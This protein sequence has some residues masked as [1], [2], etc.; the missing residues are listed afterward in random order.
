MKV[1]GQFLFHCVGGSKLKTN[2]SY[3]HTIISYFPVEI[4]H[5]KLFSETILTCIPTNCFNKN[6]IDQSIMAEVS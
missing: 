2:S 1:Y 3:F 6:M 5:I 4:S